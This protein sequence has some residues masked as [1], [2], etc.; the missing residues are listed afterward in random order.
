LKF[1]IFEVFVTVADG[2]LFSAPRTCPNSSTFDFIDRKTKCAAPTSTDSI[3][4]LSC[5]VA[6]F[7]EIAKHI[8]EIGLSISRP[9]VLRIDIANLKEA[10]SFSPQHQRVNDPY[11]GAWQTFADAIGG[12]CGCHLRRRL[13]RCLAWV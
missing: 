2:M 8:R 10:S 5:G 1:S 3:G 9:F 12:Y 13:A 4:E 7:T 6:V 11:L